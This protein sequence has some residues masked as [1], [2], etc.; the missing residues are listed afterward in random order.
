MKKTLTGLFTYQGLLLIVSSVVLTLIITGAL[1]SSAVSVYFTEKNGPADLVGPGSTLLKTEQGEM[2]LNRLLEEGTFVELLEGSRVVKTFGEV[3]D[4]R[5]SYTSEEISWILKNHTV[6][7]LKNTLY[8]VEYY[9]GCLVFLK[10]NLPENS[11]HTSVQIPPYMRK[12]PVI[13]ALLKRLIFI[14]V[15]GFLLFLLMVLLWSYSLKK[16]IVK[17]LYEIN[18]GFERVAFGDFRTSL[19]F[20]G[21]K[22][23]ESLT[24]S[25]N[26]TVEKLKALEE[27]KEGFIRDLSHD[28]KTPLTSVYGYARALKD[29]IRPEKQDEYLDCILDKSQRLNRII[30]ELL[31]YSKLQSGITPLKKERINSAVLIKEVLIAHMDYLEEEEAVLDLDLKGADIFCDPLMLSRALENIIINGVKYNDR[32]LLLRIDETVH[33]ERLEIRM[34]NNGKE[35]P[36]EIRHTLFLPS[37]RGDSSRSCKEGSGLGLSISRSIIEGHGGSIH[38]AEGDQGRVCFII[39]LPLHKTQ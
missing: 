35:I 7:P 27:F 3:F 5:E 17:P 28:L 29:N 34:G 30:E 19:S 23:I 31:D 16:R 39:N 36:K 38:L 33:E 32:G 9:N 25:F 26:N 4:K 10:K 13:R 18:R 1:F 22:E 21:L 37:V 6:T 15:M 24:H 14:G 20:K 8:K 11:L 12:P 2:V